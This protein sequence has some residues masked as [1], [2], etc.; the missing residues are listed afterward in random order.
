MDTYEDFLNQIKGVP[1]MSEPVDEGFMISLR[2]P[3]M[4]DATLVQKGGVVSILAGMM[5]TLVSG[6][7]VVQVACVIGITLVS[8]MMIASD[9]IIRKARNNR[10]TNENLGVLEI[11][12]Q[13]LKAGEE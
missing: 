10:I 7:P 9:M 11:V 8:C 12:N 3:D 4:P 1:A 6:E 2:E 5:A 13:N